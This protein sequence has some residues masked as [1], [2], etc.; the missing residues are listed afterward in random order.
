[1]SLRKEFDFYAKLMLERDNHQFY[2]SLSFRFSISIT[3]ILMKL[4]YNK[5]VF[6]KDQN[7]IINIGSGNLS[8]QNVSNTDLFPSIGQILKGQIKRNG[9]SANKYYLNLINKESVFENKWEGIIL[10]HVIEHIP[11]YLVDDCLKNMRSYLKKGGTI[12]I[13]VPDTKKYFDNLNEGELSPQ[14]FISNQLSLN[15]LFYSWEHKFMFS[16]KILIQILESNGY[17]N[18]KVCSFGEGNLSEYDAK[19]REFESL[20]ITAEK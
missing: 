13:L 4:G 17:N 15:R 2:K 11:V 18:I 3:N 9:N 16:D 19:E 1:M 14:G 8:F 7:K 5:R 20:C 6:K 10:S 12:R